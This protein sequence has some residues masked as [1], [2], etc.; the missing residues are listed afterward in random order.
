MRSHLL[1]FINEHSRSYVHTMEEGLMVA[2]ESTRNLPTGTIAALKEIAFTSKDPVVI[3]SR[4]QAEV[5]VSILLSLEE[6][7]CLKGEVL[8][9]LA[10]AIQDRF[11]FV[12][13]ASNKGGCDIFIATTYF[14]SKLWDKRNSSRG[15]FAAISK[16][17]KG[18]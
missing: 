17:F 6:G 9:A 16:W 13:S 5:D 3:F 14:F 12:A 15:R 1:A 7:E 8:N 11:D 10:A 2:V 4:P 18:V